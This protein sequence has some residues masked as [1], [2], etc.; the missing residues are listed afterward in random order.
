[1]ASAASPKMSCTSTAPGQLDPAGSP[2]GLLVSG[3]WTIR[4]ESVPPPTRRR[5]FTPLLL[6][7][8]SGG[9]RREVA[10][11]GP[12]LAVRLAA[13]LLS[14]MSGTVFRRFRWG[15]LHH[16]SRLDLPGGLP[17]ER[18]TPAGRPCLQ[19]GPPRPQRLHR[20]PDGDR[21]RACLFQAP[22]A[23]LQ[24]PLWDSVLFLT[25]FTSFFCVGSPLL[26]AKPFILPR[27]LS[28]QTVRVNVTRGPCPQQS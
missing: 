26:P 27:L 8:L 19:A 5:T 21:S 23:Q 13:T 10:K 9:Q 16:G 11:P 22:R 6:Y 3:I 14:Q 18:H 7:P 17:S 15:S 25:V 24:L 28:A 1:M 12:M 4:P 2:Y 20:L